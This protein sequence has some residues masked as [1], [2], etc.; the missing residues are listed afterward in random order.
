[1]L[2]AMQRI[3]PTISLLSSV[4]LLGCTV[5]ESKK[6][7]SSNIDELR[8]MVEMPFSAR[9]VR[10]EVF[11][12]PEYHG[13]VPGPTDFITLVAELEHLD[14]ESLDRRLEEHGSDFIVPGAA[15]PWLNHSFHALLQNNENSMLALPG[16]HNCHRYTSRLKK[17][18]K[19]VKGFICGDP[20]R[21][22]VYLTLSAAN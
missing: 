3:A 21:A 14:K 15:R 22:L 16:T 1:M 10:W 11:G 5:E 18:S 17:T 2:L 9:S 13:G 7:V 8:K 6:N 12:T 20:D 19:P 4:I